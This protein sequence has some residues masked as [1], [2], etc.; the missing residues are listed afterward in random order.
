MGLDV[1]LYKFENFEKTMELEEEF[2]SES[3]EM[4][5]KNTNGKSYSKLTEDEKNILS[6]N[7]KELRDAIF[8]GAPLMESIEID[9]SLYPEHLFKIGY[10]RSSYNSG[11]I[12]SVLRRTIGKDLYDI[13]QPDLQDEYYIRPDWN[14]ALTIATQIKEEFEQHVHRCPFDVISE[15]FRYVSKEIN[16]DKEAL[17][18]FMKEYEDTKKRVFDNYSNSNGTFYLGEN[19]LKVRGVI[20]AKN[21]LGD[22][23]YIIYEKPSEEY[24]IKEALEIVIETI[25]YVLSQPDKY[26]YRLGWS[27]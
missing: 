14:K 20:T 7:S 24:W 2:S 9:S 15:S 21:K 17:E 4:R 19:F 8:C 22:C 18:V 12:N 13:F 11:G 10:F 16:S 3:T 27:S 5:K 26:Q 1:Y 25:N 23:C 6:K